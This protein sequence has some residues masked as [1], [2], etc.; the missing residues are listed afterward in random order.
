LA[1]AEAE[2]QEADAK[3]EAEALKRAAADIK[4]AKN[5]KHR[6]R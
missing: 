2:A 6:H 4:G 3:A 5:G 1:A